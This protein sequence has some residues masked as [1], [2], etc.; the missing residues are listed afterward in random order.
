MCFF[1]TMTACTKEDGPSTQ[2]ETGTIDF[3]TVSGIWFSPDLSGLYVTYS[4]SYFNWN[5]TFGELC[6]IE[7][8]PHIKFMPIQGSSIY[9]SEW[10]G[11]FLHYADPFSGMSPDT[12]YYRVN[13]EQSVITLFNTKGNQIVNSP[14]VI[15]SSSEFSINGVTFMS[16]RDNPTGTYPVPNN[17][18]HYD[19][20]SGVYSVGEGTPCQMDLSNPTYEWRGS[21]LYVIY[22]IYPHDVVRPCSDYLS[23]P[24]QPHGSFNFSTYI[25]TFELKQI[26]YQGTTISA[27]VKN[28]GGQC[29]K[30]VCAHALN[31]CKEVNGLVFGAANNE[32][33]E[34]E[35]YAFWGCSLNGIFLC[36]IDN[37]HVSA[38]AFDEYTYKNTPLHIPQGRKQNLP[39]PW[40]NFKHIYEDVGNNI[41]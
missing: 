4:S 12:V 19:W 24:Y 36:S 6:D 2:E 35:E 29:Y 39:S 31:G 25:E 13:E 21:V 8:M 10:Q 3:S 28:N 34:I 5:G 18:W 15:Q 17:D 26:E 30:K 1:V 38:T 37:I 11:K 20:F 9:A 40:N 27:Y 14:L 41:Y 32:S 33:F 22:P 7:M 23:A 16:R